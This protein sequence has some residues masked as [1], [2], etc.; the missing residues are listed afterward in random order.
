MVSRLVVTFDNKRIS[1]MII[2]ISFSLYMGYVIC[3]SRP[4]INKSTKALST[5]LQ[6]IFTLPVSLL[7]PLPILDT[8]S[9]IETRVLKYVGA[10]QFFTIACIT[11]S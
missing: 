3:R 8:V 7:N 5:C 2:G 9:F 1:L 6:V 11:I 10:E 4:T